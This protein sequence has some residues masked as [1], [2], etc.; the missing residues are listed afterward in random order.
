MGTHPSV[1]KE[2]D[3]GGERNEAKI[4]EK[5]GRYVRVM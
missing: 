2:D 1:D 4:G 3:V 5:R